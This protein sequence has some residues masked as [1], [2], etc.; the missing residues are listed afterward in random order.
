MATMVVS[1]C[2]CFHNPAMMQYKSRSRSREQLAVTFR[3][4]IG[5]PVILD[6]DRML[7]FHQAV[8]H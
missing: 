4:K 3:A 7:K 1:E 5:L 8:Y 6:I 2:D